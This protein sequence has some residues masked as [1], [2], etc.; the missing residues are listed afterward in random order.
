MIA[1]RIQ[2]SF[3]AGISVP[4]SRAFYNFSKSDHNEL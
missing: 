2:S 1:G 3:L 4:Y